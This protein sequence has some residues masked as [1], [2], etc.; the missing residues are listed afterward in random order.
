[1]CSSD[2]NPKPLFASE[3]IRK[4]RLL[5]ISIKARVQ[6]MIRIHHNK[7]ALTDAEGGSNPYLDVERHDMPSS[8]KPTEVN[9]SDAERRLIKARLQL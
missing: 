1:M 2:L 3:S 5:R 7:H 8:K 4:L 9:C 6:F